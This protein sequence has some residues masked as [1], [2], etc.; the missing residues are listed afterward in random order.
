MRVFTRKIIAKWRSGWIAGIYRPRRDGMRLCSRKAGGGLRSIETS[1]HLQ[2]RMATLLGN[3]RIHTER[4]VRTI[5]SAPHSG[6]TL[7]WVFAYSILVGSNWN[8]FIFR[9]HEVGRVERQAGFNGWKGLPGNKR[10]CWRNA[11][12]RCGHGW[13]CHR[14]RVKKDAADHCRGHTDHGKRL[15][16]HDEIQSNCVARLAA[17]RFLQRIALTTI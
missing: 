10:R 12:W 14:I 6:Q 2:Q 16:R 5:A 13:P 1:P 17:G 8:E 15:F 3:S 11:D 7:V 9:R 4:R